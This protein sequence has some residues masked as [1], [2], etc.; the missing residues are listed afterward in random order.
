LLCC[1]APENFVISLVEDVDCGYGD[2][3]LR[4]LL[5]SIQDN[6]DKELEKFLEQRFPKEVRAKRI[7]IETAAGI[8]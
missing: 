4:A 7:E 3:E 2:R 5:T 8:E 6:V 1:N